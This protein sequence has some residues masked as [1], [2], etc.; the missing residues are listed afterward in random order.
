MSVR[1][2]APP[3]QLPPLD[4]NHVAE[5]GAGT[6]LVRLHDTGA[7]HPMPAQ[8]L[9]RFGPHPTKGRFDHHVPGT[10]GE[11]IL[12]TVR[13]IA[14]LACHDPHAAADAPGSPFDVVIAEA[15][16]GD[17]TI[18]LTAGSTI[19]VL[20]LRAPL[21]LLDCSGLWAQQTGAG[22]HLSSSAHH[23]T[24]PWARAI[25]DTYPTLHGVLYRPSTGGRCVAVAV[26]DRGAPQ[27]DG[28][29]LTMTH[30]AGHHGLIGPISEAAE[31]LGI[32]VELVG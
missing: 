8:G 29:D 16:Q 18:E 5:L 32:A 1:L 6:Q 23:R 22:A 26:T 15:A 10:H 30:P 14:Y 31:R 20:T 11:P 17:T 24:Q 21:R 9:R 27:L 3:D 4:D 12:Q 13:G 25:Y 19:S 7:R 2:P 28:A